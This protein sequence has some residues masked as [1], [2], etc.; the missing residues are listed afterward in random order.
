[1][2]TE[3]QKEKTE[4]KKSYT[5]VKFLE[6]TYWGKGKHFISVLVKSPEM[7]KEE[8]LARIYLDY[9]KEQKKSTYYAKDFWGMDV[10]QKTNNLIELKKEFKRLAPEMAR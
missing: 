2:E 8:V 6:Y 1:M 3:E 9:D 10:L 5:N 7:K 4:L